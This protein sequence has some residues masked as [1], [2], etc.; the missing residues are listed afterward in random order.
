MGYNDALNRGARQVVVTQVLLTLLIAG[1][2]GIAGGT[3][4]LLAAVYGGMATVIT[5]VWLAWRLRTAG[6]PTDA[7]FGAIF[8]SW[9]L[10]YIA[11]ALLLGAGLGYLKL[12]P[13]PL[14]SAF[15][16]SQFGFLMSV[17]TPKT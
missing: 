4:D 8:L 13:L 6:S 12:M 17:R 7:G 15:A 9:M 2:F 5:T 3:D 11:V 16:V 1:G 10:R 14:L